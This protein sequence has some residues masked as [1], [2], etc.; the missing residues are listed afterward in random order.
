MSC[1][2]RDVLATMLLGLANI[3]PDGGDRLDNDQRTFCVESHLQGERY[4]R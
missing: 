3:C 4:E 1:S 2:A